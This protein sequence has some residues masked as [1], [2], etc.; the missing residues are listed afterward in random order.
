MVKVLL[1]F[2]LFFSAN[3]F[4]LSSE[5]MHAILTVVESNLKNDYHWEASVVPRWELTP[6]DGQ[7]NFFWLVRVPIPQ[8]LK[9][10]NIISRTSS[11]G[12]EKDPETGKIINYVLKMENAEDDFE[13]QINNQDSIK[14][15]VQLENKIFYKVFRDC[16]TDDFEF[17]F[18][19]IEKSSLP[20]IATRC[21]SLINIFLPPEFEFKG[22]PKKGH[23]YH[24]SHE[25]LNS[26]SKTQGLEIVGPGIKNPLFFITKLKEIKKNAEIVKSN[27]L[28]KN[29][30]INITQRL[31]LN[32]IKNNVEFP[33]LEAQIDL[34]TDPNKM[35]LNDISIETDSIKFE[36]DNISSL[37]PGLRRYT[38]IDN[39]EYLFVSLNS[40]LSPKNNGN[41]ELYTADSGE[42]IWSQSLTTDDAN[43]W[44]SKKQSFLS[45]IKN[46][47][48]KVSFDSN[49]WTSRFKVNISEF[50]ESILNSQKK[51]LRFCFNTTEK[52]FSTHICSPI[53]KFKKN[54]NKQWRIVREKKQ[55]ATS[56]YLD[57][58]PRKLI[59]NL[60][61]EANKIFS[62]KIYLSNGVMLEFYVKTH[63]PLLIDFWFDSISKK[64]NFLGHT[65]LPIGSFTEI[66]TFDP[67]SIWT[68]IGWLPT[69]G[70][71]K[72]YWIM[73]VDPE[74]PEIMMRGEGGFLF[75]QKI[76]LENLP[77]TERVQIIPPLYTATYLANTKIQLN[78]PLN[79]NL[80]FVDSKIEKKQM[81]TKTNK[82]DKVPTNHYNW[83][84]QIEKKG[85]TQTR[86]FLMN[87]K[88]SDWLYSY[89]LYRAYSSEFSLRPGG[90]MG[91]SL[92]LTTEITLNH[93]FEN[94]FGSE[95]YAWAKQRWGMSL[96]YGQNLSETPLAKLKMNMKLLNL[97]L[98]Y[99]FTPGIWAMDETFGSIIS[100]QTINLYGLQS[101]LIGVGLFWAK[102][103]PLIFDSLF[104]L[105]SI[106]KYPKWCDMD[107]IYYPISSR[108]HNNNLENYS[109]NFHGKI[110][111]TQTFYG[112]AGFGVKSFE[113]RDYSINKKSYL[114]AAYGNLGLGLNF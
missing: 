46:K 105:I 94:F 51:T 86:S 59:E 53:F 65:Y 106:F 81:N 48:E 7:F 83:Y 84:F 6:K 108:S 27:I 25:Q 113:I 96:K 26:I 8:D 101:S 4:C 68:Q 63:Q 42:L 2:V 107:F 54:F 92:V 11:I 73:E 39:D 29:M 93:W 20:Y 74:N 75:R 79:T 62:S 37:E 36:I 35:V 23:T 32:P 110:L 82:N 100:Y 12:T 114:Q 28:T 43:T 50:N 70:D 103:M 55:V 91:K 30:G 45:W 19:N 71:F 111:W 61:L 69:I 14:F 18:E 17:N 10:N 9:I 89:S 58:K 57:N 97:E 49:L 90:F 76:E 24:F 13:F 22:F 56:F 67:K 78:A 44:E 38:G 40:F 64:I 88:D 52:A 31:L 1:M 72:N 104:S 34:K 15:H 98:R 112:E 21:D 109:I 80:K 99:R 5:S 16:E 60:Q 47:K 102:S 33:K 85:T 87:L 95:N 66:Q 3:G 77:T 41:L